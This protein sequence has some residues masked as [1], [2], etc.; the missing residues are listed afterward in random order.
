MIPI[1]ASDPAVPLMFF[2]LTLL[3]PYPL[4]DYYLL[5]IRGKKFTTRPWRVGVRSTRRTGQRFENRT[6]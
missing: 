5:R 1:F 3:C 4:F 6:F 2:A